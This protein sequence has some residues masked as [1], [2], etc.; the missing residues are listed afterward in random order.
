MAAVEAPHGGGLTR[1]EFGGGGAG[2][3]VEVAHAVDELTLRQRWDGQGAGGAIVAAGFGLVVGGARHQGRGYQ[4]AGEQEGGAA[5]EG[6]AAELGGGACHGSAFRREGV[7][8][9]LV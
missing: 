9:N 4:Y 5:E 8:V 2:V 3:E 7:S 6:A 1:Q